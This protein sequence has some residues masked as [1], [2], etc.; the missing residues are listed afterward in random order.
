MEITL[1][2][3]NTNIVI[4]WDSLEYMKSLPDKCIDLVLTD[5]P[6]GIWE[7][8][9]SNHSRWKLAKAK[10]YTDFWWDNEIPK[11]EVFNEIKRISKNQIIWGWNYFIETLE[12]SSCWIVWDKDNW[13]TDFADCELAWT[14][15]KT[16]VRK[17]KFKWMGMLQ[18]NMKNKEVRFHPTQ[19]P[20]ELFKWCLENY[21]QPWDIIL[22]CFAWSWTTAVACI[23]LWRQ[24]IVIE[25]EKDYVDV[26]EKR[27][28]NTT[29]PLFI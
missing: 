13:E 23:E 6:Y 28:R 8:W 25:K 24:Y 17:F 9:K 1:L 29:P 16:A 12:N 2:I 19:K 7:S 4:H 11:K 26:I 22:D 21:S 15:Y 3:M 10:K 14:N 20:K 18:E 27:I 5:P